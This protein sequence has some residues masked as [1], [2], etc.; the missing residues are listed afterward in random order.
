MKIQD[1]FPFDSAVVGMENLY[2]E[3]GENSFYI[4]S[5]C[6]ISKDKILTKGKHYLILNIPTKTGL[7]MT[8]I[9]L[10]DLFYY[11]SNIYLISRDI[12]TQRVS[13]VSFCLECPES[14]C[15]KYLVDVN[16]F[17]D[18]MDA[19]AIKRLLWVY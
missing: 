14:N 15:T 11:K 1:F 9:V 10:I 7:T 5:P 12:N 6:I 2:S 17:I 4:Q 18:R 13:I 3:V 8:E 19:K 16:Y